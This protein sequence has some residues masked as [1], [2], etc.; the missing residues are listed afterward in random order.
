MDILQYR[1]RERQRKQ[2]KRREEKRREVTCALVGVCVQ[3]RMSF[4]WKLS[5]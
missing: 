5:N 1:E 3:T 4:L 2:E